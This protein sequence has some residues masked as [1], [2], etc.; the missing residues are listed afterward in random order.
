M[1]Y[2][3]RELNWYDFR[4]GIALNCSWGICRTPP[5]RKKIWRTSAP[6]AKPVLSTVL[7][8]AS[9]SHWAE[10]QPAWLSFHG[11]PLTC[12]SVVLFTFR[13]FLG[14]QTMRFVN[15]GEVFLIWEKN[16]EDAAATGVVS[17][18]CWA[19]YRTGTLDF[20][21]LIAFSSFQNN[22]LQT[23]FRPKIPFRRH[24]SI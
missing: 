8:R 12:A 18:N 22:Y 9:L 7:R 10:T 20:D 5:L 2:P 11:K 23:F 21:F 14:S 16:T 15:M 17:I 6:K 3:L 24:N 19:A 4:I 1:I 13:S